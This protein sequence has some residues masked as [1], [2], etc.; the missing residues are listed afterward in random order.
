MELEQIKQ[1]FDGMLEKIKA[2]N[3]SISLI[4]WDAA[5]G[6]PKKA[7]ENR[8]KVIGILTGEVLK[9]TVCDEMK[10]CLEV[11]KEQDDKLDKITRAFAREMEKEY[12]KLAKIPE[13]EYREY[14]LEE[15]MPHSFGPEDLD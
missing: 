12:N 10:K 3:H 15:L 2:Y 1:Q 11:L 8:S 9:L 5:T 13:D 14:T 6:A 4:Y 7:V